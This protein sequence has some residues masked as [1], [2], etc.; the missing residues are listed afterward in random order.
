MNKFLFIFCLLFACG[1]SEPLPEPPADQ[2]FFGAW[3]QRRQPVRDDWITLG[4]H[5]K[6]GDEIVIELNEGTY[7]LVMRAYNESDSSG[8][9]Q[10]VPFPGDGINRILVNQIKGTAAE[11]RD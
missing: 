7:F 11:G 5:L 10:S 4:R 1:Q 2:T 9:T 3:I 6:D 8:V